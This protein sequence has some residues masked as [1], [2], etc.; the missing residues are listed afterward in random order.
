MG[1]LGTKACMCPCFLFVGNRL[2]P[3]LPSQSSRDQK[4]TFPKQGRKGMQRQWRDSKETI[5]QTWGNVLVPPLG[6]H[7]TTWL[8]SFQFSSVTHSCPTLCDPMDC[9]TSGLPGHHQLLEFTQLMSIV[10]VRTS[11]QFI[12]CCS[13]LLPPSILPRSGSFKWVNSSHQMAK[14]LEFQF[15]HQSFQWILKT[16]FL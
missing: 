10:S 13:L 3:P 1:L 8:N 12:L 4:Q 14:V 7:I 15:Q 9:S 2:Q 16:D 5:V 6:K 11:N